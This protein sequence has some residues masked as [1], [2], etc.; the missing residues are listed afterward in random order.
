MLTATVQQ[1]SIGG[2]SALLLSFDITD[3]GALDNDGVANGVIVD[4]TGLAV[5]VSTLADT[6]QNMA[7]LA[8]SAGVLIALGSVGF[9][10]F[11]TH[12]SRRVI[13]G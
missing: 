6:G 10:Q 13:R 2:S 7:W 3:G 12:K 5:N 8:S 1:S 11:Y 9:W 4:P